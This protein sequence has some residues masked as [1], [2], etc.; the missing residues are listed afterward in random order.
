MM[1]YSGVD[2]VL[3]VWWMDGS[4]PPLALNSQ[5]AVP[6]AQFKFCDQVAR[7]LF[8]AT[9]EILPSY[10]EQSNWTW[11]EVQIKHDHIHMNNP[12]GMRMVSFLFGGWGVNPPS[13]RPPTPVSS[14]LK[15]ILTFSLLIQVHIWSPWVARRCGMRW[16]VDSTR[17]VVSVSS[18]SSPSTSD[19][20]IV[21][22]D[23]WYDII[24]HHTNSPRLC[25]FKEKSS[26]NRVR[27]LVRIRQ[28]GEIALL[29][30]IFNFH[31]DFGCEFV[32]MYIIQ[33]WC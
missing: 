3:L 14:P 32:Y 10:T 33:C 20:S 24:E 19:S 1:D 21:V 6:E 12:I 17:S 18:R 2:L 15:T 28:S 9:D 31:S 16:S 23:M 29:P 25:F 5:L 27:E 30:T 4:S 13:P 8:F 22:S 11:L 7:M 26:W